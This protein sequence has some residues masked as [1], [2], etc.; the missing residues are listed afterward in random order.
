MRKVDFFKKL[1][2]NDDRL[3]LEESEVIE[4]KKVLYGLL[5]ILTVVAGTLIFTNGYRVQAATVKLNKKKVTMDIGDRVKLKVK[6]TTKKVT[7]SSD[8]SEVAR[9]SKLGNVYALS[10]G[11][12]TITAKV[13]KKTLT[14]KVT[15]TDSIGELLDSSIELIGLEI[16]VSSKWEILDEVTVGKNGKAYSTDKTLFKVLIVEVSKMKKEECAT[17]NE[18]EEN[19]K[20][21]CDSAA[22]ATLVKKFGVSSPETEII[23]TA[24]G[25]IGKSQGASSDDEKNYYTLYMRVTDNELM[26]ILL[27]EPDSPSENLAKIAQRICVETK[28]SES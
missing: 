9:V 13:G 22:R 15:V 12:C 2:Y 17:V 28:K 10:K 1:Y 14:C 19:F 16:P 21:A 24:D 4:M 23:T 11:E 5:L 7:W 6:N 27:I 3:S 26:L 18:S 8:N 25:F 20:A